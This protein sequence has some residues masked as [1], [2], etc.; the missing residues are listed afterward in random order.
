M[1]PFRSNSFLFVEAEDVTVCPED[2][3]YI[4]ERNS[5]WTDFPEM[6]VFVVKRDEEVVGWVK[7]YNIRWF[8]RT[9]YI[10]FYLYPEFRGKGISKM[11]L[12]EFV[13]LCFSTLNLNRLTAE[14]YSY[15]IRSIKVLEALG[16]RNEGCLRKARYYNGSYHD[17]FIYGLLREETFHLKG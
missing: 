15:N 13:N 16:F 1:M 2:L 8:N 4:S 5:W 10:T 6:V 14:V 12:K 7:L 17:I 9:A 3:Q 11:M